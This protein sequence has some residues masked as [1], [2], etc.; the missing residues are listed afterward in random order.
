[1]GNVCVG[2]FHEESLFQVC[3]DTANTP[4]QD[5][6]LKGGTATATGSEVSLHCS[7]DSGSASHRIGMVEGDVDASTTLPKKKRH[8][9]HLPDTVWQ[10]S[11]QCRLKAAIMTGGTY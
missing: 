10:I 2:L 6:H 8:S 7:D 11:D 4:S 1:M 9:S 5:L 3:S